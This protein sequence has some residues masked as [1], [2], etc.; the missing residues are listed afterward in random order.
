MYGT[1]ARFILKPGTAEDFGKVAM[2]QES[3]T[4]AGYRDTRV[5]HSNTNPNECWVV[6]AFESK[7][8]YDA[9]ANSPEQHERYL[10]LARFFAEDPQWH[11]G[12]IV[13][14]TRVAAASR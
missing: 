9:N 13:Y 5:Y 8:A 14:D 2:A 3:A 4:I 10:G 7:E 12:E 6:V 1:I 11:D